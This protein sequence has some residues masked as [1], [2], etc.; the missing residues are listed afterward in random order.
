MAL[1]AVCLP[2]QAH[3]NSDRVTVPDSLVQVADVQVADSGAT[4]LVRSV[5]GQT[6]SIRLRT[7]AVDAGHGVV[8]RWAGTSVVD[9]LAIEWGG[10]PVFVPSNAFMDLQDVHWANTR[11]DGPDLVL[12]LLC[13]D[14]IES[15]VVDIFFTQRRVVRRI[16]WAGEAGGKLED[17]RFFEVETRE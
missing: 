6:I 12:R 7:V 2:L 1:L 16:L 13:G 17:S 9:S 3:A 5:A 14:G 8:T 4:H 11:R 15:Y 10:S